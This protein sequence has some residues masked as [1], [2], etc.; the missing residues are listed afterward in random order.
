MLT[1]SHNPRLAR[2]RALLEKRK[3]REEEQAFVVEGVRLV[4]EALQAGQQPELVLYTAQLSERGRG[5]VEAFASA[6]VETI[7]V[8]PRLMDSVESPTFP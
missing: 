6:G 3:Q 5:V 8:A 7:E 4:E 2:V 1:S